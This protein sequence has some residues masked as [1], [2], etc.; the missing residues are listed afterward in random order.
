MSMKV[1]IRLL[2]I[3]LTLAMVTVLIAAPS[4]WTASDREL[5]LVRQVPARALTQSLDEDYTQFRYLKTTDYGATW[6]AF[7]QAGDIS[8]IEELTGTPPDFSGILTAGNEVVFAWAAHPETNP[9][10]YTIAGPNFTPVLAIPEGANAF[11]VENGGWTDM[12]RAPNGDL[13]LLTWGHNGAGSNTIWA[14]KSTNNGASWGTPWVVI[15]EPALSADAAYFHLADLTSG[16]YAFCQFQVSGAEGYDQYVMRFPLAGGTGTVVSLGVASPSQYSYYAGNCKPIAY[17]ATNSVLYASFRSA[18][19]VAVYYSGDGGQTFSA[20]EIT[21]AQRYPM[22][23]LNAATQ[24]PWVFSNYGVPTE[25]GEHCA[26]ASYDEF[27]YN[28]GSWSDPIDFACTPF[29]GGD[30][31]LYY[32]NMGY[33]WDADRGVALLNRWGVFTPEAIDATY[34]DDG[35]STWEDPMS[36]FYFVDD[37]IDVG[38]IQNAELVGGSGGTAYIITSGMTG[39]S[40]LEGPVVT[41]QTLDPS[42]PATGMP[43]YV[44]SAMLHDNVQVDAPDWIQVEY[45]NSTIGET[46]DDIAGEWGADSCQG[47]DEFN[48][49]RWFFTLAANHDDS[50]FA[51]GDT[52]WF[53]VWA[54]DPPGNSGFGPLQGIV[55]GTAFLGIEDHSAPVHAADLRLLGNYPN[56]FNPSTRIEFTVPNTSSISLKIFNTLGQEV[57]VLADNV[58]VGAGLYAYHF[59]ASDLPSGVYIYRLSSETATDSKKMIL[60]K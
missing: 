19:G 55:V 59:D 53:D 31:F 4:N 49:G 20:G 60:V 57:A 24:T 42:T 37:E 12:A 38:S 44:I 47:C 45:Y 56:P 2:T 6:T 46:Y 33:W 48:N 36:L 32:M 3:M 52:V 51:N 13:I 39:I 58:K 28:G 21:A 5:G 26:W 17:D 16:D 23:T 11:D 34:T 43:P 54:T 30:Y 40:D 22:V 50:D 25:P 41:E 10:I 7:T 18:S 29:D 15:S 1:S 14:V 8:T 9:G 35:G 27:G